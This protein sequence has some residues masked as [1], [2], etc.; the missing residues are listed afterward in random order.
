MD[1]RQLTTTD[2]F[3]RFFLQSPGPERI[4]GYFRT[5]E[6]LRPFLRSAAW[7][8]SVTGYYLNIAGNFDTVRLSYFTVSPGDARKA[9]DDLCAGGTVRES[10]LEERPHPVV[11][12]EPYG[13]EELRFR[14]FLCAYTQV[15][16]DIMERDLL[17]ARRLMATFRWQVFAARQPVRP[18]F[19][20][21]FKSQSPYY[22][23][24]SA[25]DR[26]QFWQD[27]AEWPDPHQVDWAHMMVNMVLPGDWNTKGQWEEFRTPRAPL[28]LEQIG[29]KVD[30]LGFGTQLK[31]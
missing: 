24:L 2:L 8:E 22:N 3:G 9:V 25:T 26:E 29:K 16:L 1:F 10:L 20:G 18:H 23:A 12:S 27:L 30:N 11:I 31:I 21:T 14:R 7:R 6:A 19:E 15:G 28:T 5:I 13:G 17:N 4:A